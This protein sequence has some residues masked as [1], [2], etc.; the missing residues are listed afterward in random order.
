MCLFGIAKTSPILGPIGMQELSEVSSPS[1]LD[2]PVT[3]ESAQELRSVA[4]PTGARVA[5][6]TLSGPN[7]GQAIVLNRS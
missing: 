2:Y 3:G 6:S 4:G 1:S 7:I 5:T